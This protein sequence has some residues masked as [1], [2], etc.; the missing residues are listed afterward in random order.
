MRKYFELNMDDY[1]LHNDILSR[2]NYDVFDIFEYLNDPVRYSRI[3]IFI[4]MHLFRFKMVRG[5]R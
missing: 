2:L 4:Y 1:D 5:R 3:Y